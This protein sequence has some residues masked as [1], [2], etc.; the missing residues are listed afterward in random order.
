MNIPNSTF[1][2]VAV[3]PAAGIGSRM[4]ATCPKQYLKIGKLTI[5]EHTINALLK[6]PRI[7][8]IIVAINPEDDYF[9][10]LALA[11]DKRIIVV[12][13]GDN[14]LIRYYQGFA[15]LQNILRKIHGR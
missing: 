5:L 6:H 1:P 13:G 3:I 2:I 10:H 9:Y 12:K 11:K 8:Q 7:S 15:I 4:Q 14:V